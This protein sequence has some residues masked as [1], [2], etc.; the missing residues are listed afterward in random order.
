[1]PKVVIDTNV[2]VSTTITEKG[3]RGQ[4]TFLPLYNSIFSSLW[5]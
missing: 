5:A 4:A 2:F 3:K 1:M